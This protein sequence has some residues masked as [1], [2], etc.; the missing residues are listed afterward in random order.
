MKIHYAK[1]QYTKQ[2]K[3]EK[4]EHLKPSNVM[5]KW[6]PK[7]PPPTFQLQKE[8]TKLKRKKQVAYVP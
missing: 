8:G 1:E 3:E 4:L 5:R 2:C 7:P 6:Q